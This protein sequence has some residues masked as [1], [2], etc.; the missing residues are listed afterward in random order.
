MA[1][2]TERSDLGRTP[3]HKPSIQTFVYKAGE[4]IVK[5]V[6]AHGHLNPKDLHPDGTKRTIPVEK[7]PDGKFVVKLS[8]DQSKS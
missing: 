1:G 5:I 7:T 6:D 3:D 8:D 2:I 4:R